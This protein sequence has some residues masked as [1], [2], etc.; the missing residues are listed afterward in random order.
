M[1]LWKAR[2]DLRDTAGSRADIHPDWLFPSV[3]PWFCGR[4]SSLS[5]PLLWITRAHIKHSDMS[6]PTWQLSPCSSRSLKAEEST[7]FSSLFLRISQKSQNKDVSVTIESCDKAEHLLAPGLNLGTGLHPKSFPKSD[8]P[9]AYKSVGLLEATGAANIK[10][11]CRPCRAPP[12]KSLVP[13][14]GHMP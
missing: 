13:A 3:W 14:V 12:L 7:A 11:L 2:K 8:T 4:K 1:F 10:A 6:R 9:P 5:W